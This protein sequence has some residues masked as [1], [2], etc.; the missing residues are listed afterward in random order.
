MKI[1][2][3]K[4]LSKHN[5]AV[6]IG[7]I[8]VL[9]LIAYLN[10]F[11]NEF[12]WDDEFLIQKNTFLTHF[13]YLPDI[14]ISNTT[15][16]FGG[17]DNFYRPVQ[18]FLYQLTYQ[19][20]GLQ[21]FGFH[22]L[23]ISIHLSNSILIYYL[24][25]KQFKNKKMGLVTSAIWVVH[26][27][28]IEAVTYM[29]GTADPLV[30]FFILLTIITHIH[31]RSTNKYRFLVLGLLSFILALLSKE[32][33][34]ITVFLILIFDGFKFKDFKKTLLYSLPYVLITALY[35][36]A[37]ATV[38]NFNNNLSSYT[39]SNIYTENITYRIYTFLA[40]I[41]EYVKTIFLPIDLHMERDFPIYT[42]ILNLPVV[43]G[44]IIII[45]LILISVYGINSKNK[46]L[47]FGPIWFIGLLLP[48]SG[49]F[50]PINAFFYEH[51]LYLPSLGLIIVIVTLIG[52]LK[53]KYNLIKKIFLIITITTLTTLTI[54]RNKDWRDPIIF[55]NN[56]LEYNEGTARVHNNLAMAYND[57]G[58][59]RLA[60]RHYLKAIKLNDSYP[61]THYNLARL[62]LIENNIDKAIFHLERSLEIDPS[63]SLSAQLLK[64][65]NQASLTI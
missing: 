24:I 20:F 28:H 51:W 9:V 55:Y 58:K 38:F 6:S 62:Y 53:P 13:K 8:L 14:L 26:P 34:L 47:T 12:L 37:R 65:I 21:P 35:I 19:V 60:K 15:A 33:A 16:G 48:V 3:K 1:V 45:G 42:E 31:F 10:S 32:F 30:S 17:V 46:Y 40:A 23:N 64:V 41:F 5:L 54:V 59:N 61:Q 49:I 36:L 44:L 25:S 27:I 2:V 4:L 63:F 29:S 52:K 43:M 18:I 22:L 39:E 56:I 50:W 7:I 57:E 11:N